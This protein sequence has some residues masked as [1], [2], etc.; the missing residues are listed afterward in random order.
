M[1]VEELISELRKIPNTQKEV[2]VEKRL[3]VKEIQDTAE[4]VVIK[5]SERK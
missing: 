2:T 3:N 5:I 4:T 1:T